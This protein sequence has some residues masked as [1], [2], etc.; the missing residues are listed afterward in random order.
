M[1]NTINII[2]V[3]AITQN[4]GKIGCVG[5]STKTYYDLDN[6]PCATEKFSGI[7]T[8]V[9]DYFSSQG[10]KGDPAETITLTRVELDTPFVYQPDWWTTSDYRYPP[11]ATIATESFVQIEVS[12]ENH[13]PNHGKSYL[14]YGFEDYG[15]IPQALV[16]AF[17]SD[18]GLSTGLFQN[19]SLLPGG[20]RIDKGDTCKD[21][22]ALEPV[23]KVAVAHTVKDLTDFL[24][25]T[26]ENAGCFH[27][28]ACPG[29]NVPAATT[30]RSK[31]SESQPT[32]TA[33]AGVK[34]S[35]T[36]IAETGPALN[37]LA[38][39]AQMEGLQG[40]KT[41]GSTISHQVPPLQP[42]QSSA[43][44]NPATEGNSPASGGISTT[45][46]NPAS[47]GENT[48]GTTPD[49]GSG[50]AP[51]KQP[52]PITAPVI[53]IGFSVLTANVASNFL[54]G[55]QTLAPGSVPIIVSGTTF[56]LLPSASA[57]VID[58]NT[59]PLRSP[60]ISSKVGDNIFQAFKN[61]ETT[62]GQGFGTIPVPVITIDG[63]LVTANSASQFI[64][65][66]QTLSTGGTPVTV[67]GKP[68]SLALSGSNLIVN[69][70]TTALPASSRAVQSL[71]PVIKIGGQP[72]TANSVS[73]PVVQGQTLGFDGAPITVAGSTF[74]LASSGSALIINGVTNNIPV[75]FPAIVPSV[76]SI[77]NQPI[78][79]NSASQFIVQ[80]Q[81]LA[82]GGSPITVA[83]TTFSLVPS[84]TALVANGV[85]STLPARLGAAQPVITIGSQAITANA[86]SQFLVQSQT[87]IA[88]GPPITVAG[89]TLSLAPSGTA[90]AVN[91][92]TSALSVPLRT[93]PTAAPSIII[94]KNQAITANSQSEF[95][96][97]N[98]IL[99]PGGS[100]ITVSGTTYSL[101][102]HA[103]IIV[104]NGKTAT[105]LQV[106]TQPVMTPNPVVAKPEL[107]ISG[108]TAIAGGTPIT[109]SGVRVSLLSSGNEIV[110]GSST[111]ALPSEPT[112]I[113]TIGSQ[114]VTANK[115]S[116]YIFDSQTL[117]PG[118]PAVTISG[119]KV[120]LASGGSDV[121]VQRSTI[122]LTG[123]SATGVVEKF[124][125]DAIRV[126]PGLKKMKAF[127]LF[128]SMLIFNWA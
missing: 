116:E 115:V 35:S 44:P 90:I 54:V 74:P 39:T 4:N 17:N 48:P 86:A 32:S 126:R 101:A 89:T 64:V 30:T 28:G 29:T 111:E 25:L 6:S 22:A 107:I 117:I 91:R 85:T 83:G 76:I 88:G 114:I 87:L 61:L 73:R 23:I 66:G 72:I 55:S 68:I 93:L 108:Q 118:G 20:P 92:V 14:G 82:P 15:F 57:L 80:D 60:P 113:L 69:G 97:G 124:T 19:A 43:R 52:F 18:F 106:G 36:T 77:D 94:G 41:Q 27:P 26:I 109:I 104:I 120:S 24:T 37:R 119:V 50:G 45:R 5:I 65:Q 70:I 34:G 81:T 53:T 56:S 12:D 96:I 51:E 2:T 46:G 75:L 127:L 11:T 95:T 98:Q 122:D 40:Q 103:S 8:Y 47:G 16:N 100:P 121:V 58:G 31:K 105:P 62:Q 102:P 3:P 63:Q 21:F 84:G 1:Y 10:L 71:I 99:S 110:I 33:P 67:L 49:T 7:N 9:E 38:S 78:T 125:G 42:D 59:S 128:I 13:D 79:A 112:P 123:S